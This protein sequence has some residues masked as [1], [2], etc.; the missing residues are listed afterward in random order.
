M[1]RNRIVNHCPDRTLREM[2]LQ[3][4]APR[5]SNNEEVPD[6]VDAWRNRGQHQIADT[7]QSLQISGSDFAATI[8]PSIETREFRPQHRRLQRIETRVKAECLVVVFET[9]AVI[10]QDADTICETIIIR[11]Y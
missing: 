3:I 7:G 11:R 6:R 9:R 5:M 2:P 10:A 1:W 4:V 8:I